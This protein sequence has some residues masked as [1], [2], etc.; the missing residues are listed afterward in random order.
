[1]DGKKSWYIPDGWIP[2]QKAGE[3]SGYEGHEALI[4]LNCNEEEAK[5]RIDVY[6]E[7]KAPIENVMFT[8]GGKRVK[9]FRMDKPEE[10]GGVTLGRLQQYALRVRSD[11][12]IVVQFGRMDVTQPNCSYIGLMGYGE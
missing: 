4:V 6:F 7:D 1:M 8:V 11:V 10:I 3:E 2:R 12:E 5:I 9:C